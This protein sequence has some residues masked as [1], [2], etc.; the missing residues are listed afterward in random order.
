M[1][2]AFGETMVGGPGHSAYPQWEQRHDRLARLH[3]R[4]YQLPGGS[5][6]QKIT[7]MLAAEVEKVVEGLYTE[8]A[9]SER[10]MVFLATVLQCSPDA[11]SS[12][13]IHNLI[14]Q[15]LHMWSDGQYERLV[16]QA[17]DCVMWFTTAPKRKS[18]T[19]KLRAF[20]R[21]CQSGKVSAGLRVLTEPESGIHDLD[22]VLPNKDGQSITVRDKLKAQHP[23]QAPANPAAFAECDQ[24]P[25]L[26]EIDITERG[27]EA[28]AKKLHGGAGP[29]GGDAQLWQSLLL[30]SGGASRRL[31]RAIAALATQLANTLVPWQQISALRACR[32]IP[33]DKRPGVRP[34]GVG[35]AVMRLMGKCIIEQLR[36]EI[37][38]VFGTDQLCAG[39]SGGIEAAIHAMVELFER[40]ETECIFLAD[41]ANAFNEISRPAALYNTRVYCPRLS[42][43]VFNS[44]KGH[45]KLY[46][47]GSGEMIYSQEGTTQGCATAMIVYGLG[48]LPLTKKCKEGET[49][50]PCDQCGLAESCRCEAE[51]PNAAT[52]AQP[53]EAPAPPSTTP[54]G[55]PHLSGAG[56]AAGPAAAATA[57]GPPKQGSKRVASARD[58]QPMHVPGRHIPRSCSLPPPQTTAHPPPRQCPSTPQARCCTPYPPTP[59]PPTATTAEQSRRRRQT[60]YADDSAAG[61]GVQP[62]FEWFLILLKNGPAV[63]YLLQLFK[64][65]LLVKP[66]HLE[67][68]QAIFA[69]YLETP[70]RPGIKIVTGARFLGGF[71]GT[72]AEKEAF[73]RG[74]VGEW[75]KKIDAV[76]TAAIRYPQ[77]AH[78]AMQRCLQAQ[79]DF[80]MRAIDAAADAYQPITTALRTRYM[81]KLFGAPLT[82]A[83]EELALQ[84]VRSGG[85]GVLNTAIRAPIARKASLDGTIHLTKAVKTAGQYS[86]LAHKMQMRMARQAAREAQAAEHAKRTAAALEQLSPERVRAVQRTIHYRTGG[87]LTALPCAADHTDLTA[88]EFRDN[89]CM[90]YGKEPPNLPSTCEGC[91]KQNSVAH[92]LNCKT[93]GLV[94]RRHDELVGVV[95]DVLSKVVGERNVAR[96]VTLRRRDDDGPLEEDKKDEDGEREEG[97]GKEGEREG[98]GGERAERLLREGERD[99][100]GVRADLVARKVWNRTDGVTSFDIA[101]IAADA[102]SYVQKNTHVDKLLARKEAEKKGNYKAVCHDLRMSFTPV[103]VTTDGIWGREANKLVRHLATELIHRHEGW[104]GHAYSDVLRYLRFRLHFALLRGV[105]LCLRGSRISWRVMRR[106]FGDV[107]GAVMGLS[108]GVN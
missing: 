22:T 105:S 10:P 26:Q 55:R 60:W 24:L 21:L 23:E 51:E 14:K 79:W 74:K 95:G 5:L 77:S 59:D 6:G 12:N 93:G 49:K 8:G 100:K 62:V 68:A 75:V 61:G 53:H 29:L 96:E 94:I 43:F 91:G 98:S 44:Y 108:E 102:P 19:S 89:L 15:R 13:N 104:K 33:L 42:R 20:D 38:R 67:K 45:A 82:P 16:E 27:V 99:E 34:I 101:V 31:R 39:V 3:L 83:D 72:E 56:S 30:R 106:G 103:V 41:A 48:M 1:R 2:E 47:S 65:V 85:I 86:L 35:E 71:I 69:D 28:C 63:R 9:P 107:D 76:S 88:E 17:E 18:D 70:T 37:A 40:P 97:G 50:P 7:H 80:S 52:S 57:Q 25:P 54:E 11:T 84:P 78:A 36:P 64:C 81:P 90:R 46:V 58:A 92:A 73:V 32:L 87:W 66:E 4:K